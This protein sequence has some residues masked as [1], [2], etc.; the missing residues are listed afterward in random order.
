MKNSDHNQHYVKEM[1]N[2]IAILTNSARKM[3]KL[4]KQLLPA[5]ITRPKR[6]AVN[7]VGNIIKAITGNLDNE[8]AQRYDHAIQELISSHLSIKTIVGKQITLAQQAISEFNN[9]ISILRSN[10]I[11]IRTRMV[12]MENAIKN[13]T[14]HS[15]KEF[16]QI[17]IYA[18]F[19]QLIFMINNVN[20][21]MMTIINAMT[22]A[23]FNSYHPSIMDPEDL[24]H[25]LN[26]IQT[27]LTSVKLPIDPI[28]SNTHYMERVI[29]VKAYAKP[30]QIVFM[31]MVPLVEIIPYDYYNIFPLPI[32]GNNIT[33]HSIIPQ[34]PFLAIN[35]HRYASMK[36][37]CLEVIPAEYLCNTEGDSNINEDSP[38]EVQLLSFSNNY[39]QCYHR[40]ENIH[41]T[42]TNKVAQ[43]QWIAVFPTPSKVKKICGKEQELEILED[44]CLIKMTPECSLNADGIVLR[45]YE[46]H[47]RMRNKPEIPDLNISISRRNQS[48]IQ[49]TED[50]H[51]IQLQNITNIAKNLDDLSNDLRQL[52]DPELHER[53][54]TIWSIILYKLIFSVLLGLLIR[55]YLRTCA[56]TQTNTGPHQTASSDPGTA[57][58]DH[59]RER[60]HLTFA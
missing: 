46:T 43:N 26:Y 52:Q 19:N 28:I 8:D 53:P 41:A 34:N 44:T 10:Q 29:T 47:H 59:V 2:Y 13:L 38:C 35:E 45:T 37:Q 23:K 32:K 49:T 33:F 9:S 1:S 11:V 42:W 21:I 15:L 16:K 4:K 36:K 54:I 20:D 25:E 5:C 50:L 14:F 48:P 6:G 18:I 58:V 31:L 60:H 17:S 22:F 39:E 27:L 12:Q 40:T 51:P 7:F 56:K 55:R 57:H 24:T 3:A 30:A